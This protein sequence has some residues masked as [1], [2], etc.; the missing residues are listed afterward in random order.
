MS[1]LYPNW[2]RDRKFVYFLSAS[3]PTRAIFRAKVADRH[4]AKYAD[5]ENIERGPF[6]FGDWVGLTP[7]D[8]PLAVRNSTIEDVYAWDLNA[9]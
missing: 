4:V 7:D 1:I 2:S 8:A 3:S 6:F 9:R 5:L